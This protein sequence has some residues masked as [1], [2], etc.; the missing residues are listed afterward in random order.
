MKR[1]QL[2]IEVGHRQ[3]VLLNELPSRLNN[4]AHQ[5]REDFIGVIQFAKLHLHQG[6]D[7]GIECCFA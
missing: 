6:P 5:L 7:V 1:P 2:D 4:I 3:R